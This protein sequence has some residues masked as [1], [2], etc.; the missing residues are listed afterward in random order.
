MNVLK[1][2]CERD[3]INSSYIT[4]YANLLVQN[5]QAQQGPAG[6][7]PEQA[8]ELQNTV[9]EAA[10]VFEKS[11]RYNSA[12]VDLWTSYLQF[13]QDYQQILGAEGDELIKQLFERAIQTVGKHMKSAQIW[14]QYIN[15][16][17]MMM[18]MGF[19]FLLCFAAVQTPLLQIDEIYQ[20]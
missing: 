9:K 4:R 10:K 3:P 5:K 19:S 15:F 6:Q 11:I 8:T 7:N 16:E 13:L 17:T 14:I 2:I 18:H 20:K 1:E 12:Q